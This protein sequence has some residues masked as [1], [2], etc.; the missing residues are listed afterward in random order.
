MTDRS[1][2]TSR[3]HHMPEITLDSADG[4]AIVQRPGRALL[5]LCIH[6]WACTSCNTEVAHIVKVA[7]EIAAWGCDVALIVCAQPSPAPYSLPPA[8]RVFFDPD[9]EFAQVSGSA[10]PGVVIADEWADITFR[11]AAGANHEF[12]DTSRLLSEIRYLA[13]RCPECEGEAL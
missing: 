2:L 10:S 6:D 4:R 13:T 1:Q 5:A 3:Q 7:D 9:D 11:R 8:F 12:P